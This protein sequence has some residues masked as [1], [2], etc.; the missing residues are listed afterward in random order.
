MH[1]TIDCREAALC[2][3]LTDEGIAF[4]T[5]SLDV[6]DILVSSDHFEVL[7]ERKTTADLHASV[8]DGR[9]KDQKAR[10]GAW[11]H[12]SPI[13]QRTIAYVVEHFQFPACSMKVAKT[14][15][16][17]TG[18]IL[19][20]AVRDGIQVFCVQDIHETAALVIHLTKRIDKY[21]AR[22]PSSETDQVNN[23]TQISVRRK[24]NLGGS[25]ECLC[26]QLCQVPGISSKKAETILAASSATSM[27]GLI[28]WLEADRTRLQQIAGIG[29][30]L[31]KEI[32]EMLL[33]VS[34]T[35]PLSAQA[36][37]RKLKQSLRS[38]ETRADA[39]P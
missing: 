3:I 34:E 36:K 27:A 35:K 8:T 19:N 14:T 13:K 28:R 24:D 12:Q 30:K 21:E 6:G 15:D 16:V 11:T 22:N 31:V 7:I 9:Y 4:T 10:L 2:K 29:P 18:C 23:S 25:R 33:G 1:L 5:A 20:T 17:I 26:R 39:I 37:L 32:S 38:E